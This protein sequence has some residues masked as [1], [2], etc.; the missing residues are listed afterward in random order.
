[1]IVRTLATVCVTR[2][3]LRHTEKPPQRLAYEDLVRTVTFRSLRFVVVLACTLGVGRPVFAQSEARVRKLGGMHVG[4][5][6]GVSG[7]GAAVWDRGH[8]T[9]PTP[10]GMFLGAEV[11]MFGAIVSAGR[12]TA[13][14]GGSSSVQGGVMRSYSGNRVYVGGEARFMV[15]LI[16]FR[17]GAYL[18]VRGQTGWAVLPALS[19]GAGW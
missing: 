4:A 11:G 5:P 19:V 13:L 14:D 8:H 3:A 6:L 16:T 10:E 18:R 2:T 17:G 7:F 9:W 15:W 1:M 12:V